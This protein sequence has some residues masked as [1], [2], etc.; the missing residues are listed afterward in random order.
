MLQIRSFVCSFIE[1]FAVNSHPPLTYP[2]IS[3]SRTLL[4]IFYLQFTRSEESNINL[5]SHLPLAHPPI[6]LQTCHLRYRTRQYPHLKVILYPSSVPTNAQVLPRISFHR[7]IKSQAFI[8]YWASIE[9][10]PLL[11]MLRSSSKFPSPFTT[12]G[13]SM[14]FWFEE[15]SFLN[16]RTLYLLVRSLVHKTFAVNSHPPRS[17]TPPSQP[18]DPSFSALFSLE[19][20]ATKSFNYYF[21]TSTRPPSRYFSW[22]NCCGYRACPT[23]SSQG[24]VYIPFKHAHKST[25]LPLSSTSPRSILNLLPIYLLSSKD[26]RQCVEV[27]CA[28][29]RVTLSIPFGLA[30]HQREKTKLRLWAMKCLETSFVRSLGHWTIR[31]QNIRCHH[32]T[33]SFTPSLPH[34]LP[35]STQCAPCRH[36]P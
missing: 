6:I 25:S 36:K 8:Y 12:G 29:R 34:S 22:P 4:T 18:H 30:F 5:P 24:R 23:S 7:D 33:P 11:P 17:S 3:T 35:F 9:H 32:L 20:T 13:L 26:R 27:W 15:A 1:T 10:K 2:A 28:T 16:V 21:P 31:S 14:G 19:L